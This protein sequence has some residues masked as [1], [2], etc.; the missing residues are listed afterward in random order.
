MEEN[1]NELNNEKEAKLE[2]FINDGLFQCPS[3]YTEWIGSPVIETL[4][5]D[6]ETKT[7]VFCLY[8]CGFIY[9]DDYKPKIKNEI[10]EWF[11]KHK[12]SQLKKK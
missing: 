2:E 3:C 5:E 1:E 6:L 10:D 12:M 4:N 11:R 9:L 8:G 7:Q